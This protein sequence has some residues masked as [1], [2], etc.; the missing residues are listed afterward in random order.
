MSINSELNSENL[1][2]HEILTSTD[3]KMPNDPPINF[4]FECDTFQLHAFNSIEQG[5]HILVSAP[6]S[7]GKTL[8]AEYAIHYHLKHN[9]RIIYTSPIKSLSNEK[10]KEFK[11]KEICKVGLLTGDN[12]INPDADLI[13]ATAEILR[14]SLYKIKQDKKDKEEVSE[15]TS[16]PL[17]YNILDNVGCVIMDE[18]H[19]INDLD[20]GKVWEETLILLDDSIQ[21]VLL[22]ATIDRVNEFA[23]WIQSIKKKQLSLIPTNRRIIPLT[24]SIFVNDE[25]YTVLDNNDTFNEEIYHSTKRTYDKLK[26]DPKYNPTETQQ[27]N[28]LV[29]YLIKKDL[30]QT[31]F[32][33][34][35]RIKCEDYANS[36]AQYLIEPEEQAEALR[37]FDYNIAPYRKIYESLP[38]FITVRQLIQKGIAFHHSGLIPILKEII[39]IIFKKGLIKILFAT[40]TFAVGVNMPTRT[41]VFT[42]LS[43]NTSRGRRFLNTAEYKQMSGRAG[44][45]GMDTT[46][47]VIL[48]TLYDFPELNDLK[49]VMI[50]TMPRISSKFKIDYAYCLKTLNSTNTSPESLF[51]SSLLANEINMSINSD[52]NKLINIET[53]YNQLND[54]FNSKYSNDI[55]TNCN[56][57]YSQEN[58]N[59]LCGSDFTIKL[60]PKQRK[61][62]EKLKKSVPEQIYNEYK[63]IKKHEE[64]YKNCKNT[65]EDQ[66]NYI[67]TN[68]DKIYNIF[69]NKGFINNNDELTVKGIIASLVNDCN[70]IL[71]AE[72]ISNG[73]LNNLDTKQIIALVSIFT[74]VSVTDNDVI[75]KSKNL[76]D[77]YQNII[78]ITDSYYQL[79]K[80]NRLYIDEEYWN[81]NNKY[82]DLT[83]DWVNTDD[84]TNFEL[85]RK[86]MLL[87]LEEIN[88]Y[89]GNFV[90]NM[91]KIYNILCNIKMLCNILKYYELAQKLEMVDT[92]L[93][94]DIVNVNS[95]YL[96]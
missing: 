57:I 9:K 28:T 66:N 38:Q 22:S 2:Q 49:S 8:C 60:T 92:L 53:E 93:L 1:K 36:V 61:D 5:K 80:E 82:I 32:F 12:K 18:V 7:S 84:K 74:N 67:K 43:K 63:L 91:L 41:V 68:T 17:E 59:T 81:I 19:F 21:L 52:K 45:R 89:E 29:K 16:N 78:K 64:E 13:V 88:E 26:K 55:I 73:M 76:N 90:R 30:L 72:I 15:N 79:E 42:N 62:M 39:E 33:S 50:K 34:F 54:I 77:E 23:K 70:G 71:L 24:H 56:K 51:N 37:I 14:N 86:N 27:I 25:L 4:P 46:G 87:Y 40:E 69:E 83:Y 94:K 96:K 44:R 85:L 65:I 20:R 31:I 11:D 58:T 47:T 3:V 6:T 95:L 10:Y 35:S 48:M 75:Y